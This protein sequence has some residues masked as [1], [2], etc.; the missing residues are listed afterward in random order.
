MNVEMSTEGGRDRE[1]K[2][3]VSK[4]ER[5]CPKVNS[6][7]IEG[8]TLWILTNISS[9]AKDSGDAQSGL[10]WALNDNYIL[11]YQ[12]YGQWIHYM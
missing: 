5:I 4:M 9:Q 3:A 12:E 7:I 2:G 8:S 10:G 1:H 11:F 6:Q